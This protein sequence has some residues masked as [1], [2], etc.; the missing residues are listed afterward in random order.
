MFAKVEQQI[1]QLLAH[2]TRAVNALED[3]ARELRDVANET[4]RLAD[5]V[6]NY[7]GGS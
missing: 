2:A 7:R 1:E 6:N 5:A 4:R 3:I